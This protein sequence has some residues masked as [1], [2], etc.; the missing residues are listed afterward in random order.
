MSTTT[1]TLPAETL[2][3]QATEAAKAV[4]PVMQD[5]AR[6][7][8]QW[9]KEGKEFAQAQAPDIAKQIVA[10]GFAQAVTWCIIDLSFLLA[11]FWLGRRFWS[12]LIDAFEH[13]KEIPGVPLTIGYAI[14]GIAA[15]PFLISF[16]SSVLDAVQVAVAPKVYL[17]EYLTQLVKK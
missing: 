7:L 4:V 14:G 3:A 9:L 12:M 10:W 15:I 2:A 6:E 17:I 5:Y 1:T 16:W 8:L 11:F 13:D